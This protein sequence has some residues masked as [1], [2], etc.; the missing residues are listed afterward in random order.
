MRLKREAK[1]KAGFYVEPEAKLVSAKWL[2]WLACGCL[3]VAAEA[4]NIR[5]GS[6]GQQEAAAAGRQAGSMGQQQLQQLAPHAA[7]QLRLVHARQQQRRRQ[8]CSSWV[9]GPLM[10]AASCCVW[11]A[12]WGA[13]PPRASGSCQPPTLP[14][15]PPFLPA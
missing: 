13:S 3:P 7:V 12:L 8:R 10:M 14:C 4:A 1:A 9:R 15:L 6:I 2:A 11:L 5:G